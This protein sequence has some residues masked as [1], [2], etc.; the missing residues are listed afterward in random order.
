LVLLYHRQRIV[1]PADVGFLEIDGEADD[2]REVRV[3]FAFSK[4]RI[5]PP[6]VLRIA[7][8]RRDMVLLL[9]IC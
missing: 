5:G 6:V 2:E 7:T 9:S 3:R 1:E 8:L 4:I